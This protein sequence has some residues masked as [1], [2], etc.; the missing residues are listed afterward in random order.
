MAQGLIVP[1]CIVLN[2]VEGFPNEKLAAHPVERAHLFGRFFQQ[3]TTKHVMD[4]F[5]TSAHIELSALLPD[6]AVAESEGL[7]SNAP[8]AAGLST[9]S[10][11]DLGLEFV[12]VGLRFACP[13]P[14]E[15]ERELVVPLLSRFQVLE[16]VGLC[17]LPE[18]SMVPAE[19]P[20]VNGIGLHA[21]QR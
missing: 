12:R 14:V 16:K 19:S 15:E 18:L 4:R 5:D 11:L 3:A 20:C 2:E 21:S 8:V 9:E 10:F 13:V 7:A 17:S 6:D 1:L